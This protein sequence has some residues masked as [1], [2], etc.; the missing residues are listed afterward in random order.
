MS[1]WC[2]DKMGVLYCVY[3]RDCVCSVVY[4]SSCELC[5]YWEVFRPQLSCVR[6]SPCAESCDY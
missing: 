4:I 1:L 6:V 2:D 3:M 5:D